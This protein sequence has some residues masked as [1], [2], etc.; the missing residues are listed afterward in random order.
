LLPGDR[1]VGEGD[2]LHGEAEFAGA[3]PLQDLLIGLV[4]HGR[5]QALRR[6]VQVDAG[7]PQT[8]AGQGDLSTGGLADLDQP[9]RFREGEGGRDQG[10]EQELR[11]A[12]PEVVDDDVRL[13]LGVRRDQF[14]VRHGGVD[15]RIGTESLYFAEL[16]VI[17]AGRDDPPGAEQAGN[18]YCE[19]AGDTG[20]ALD[21]HRFAGDETGRGLDGQPGDR[22]TEHRDDGRVE[23]VRHRDE[24]VARHHGQLRQRAVRQPWIAEADQRPVR[25]S[26]DAVERGD[27]RQRGDEVRA[28]V[29]RAGR[30]RLVDV[31]QRDRLHRDDHLPVAGHRIREVLIAGN[32]ADLVQYRCLHP[33]LLYQ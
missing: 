23:V 30:D 6:A 20:R 13:R 32:A 26:P 14:L 29:V 31:L 28:R 7:G 4:H 10:P 3:G 12:A 5:V 21:Q 18:L 8:A 1:D 11:R 17:P 19:P 9:G 22:R 27:G 24:G 15:H 2:L 16:C 25:Q 33:S